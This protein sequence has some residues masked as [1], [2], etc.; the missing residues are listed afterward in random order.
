VAN[1]RYYKVTIWVGPGKELQL[2]DDLGGILDS[3]SILQLMPPGGD[4]AGWRPDDDQEVD[5]STPGIDLEVC[6]HRFDIF[7]SC[8]KMTQR[9]FIDEPHNHKNSF[10]VFF[11]S[12]RLLR[13]S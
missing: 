4:L 13:T 11:A 8:L 10:Y 2:A 12:C 6:A 9:P 5:T 7:S 1:P 3:P